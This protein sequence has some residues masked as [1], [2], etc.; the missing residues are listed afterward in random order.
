MKSLTLPRNEREFSSNEMMTF[1]FHRMKQSVLRSGLLPL[2]FSFTN[3]FYAALMHISYPKCELQINYGPAQCSAAQ[4]S[5]AQRSAAQRS[6]AQR[7]AAQ[8]SAAQRSAAQRSA[9]QRSAAQRSAA[10]RSAA[11]RSTAL[12]VHPILMRC[13]FCADIITTKTFIAE[14]MVSCIRLQ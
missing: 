10:Q 7:S 3:R 5:A 9:A 1:V 11:Q 4:R 12:F 14:L 6:A 8:R 13:L 2:L